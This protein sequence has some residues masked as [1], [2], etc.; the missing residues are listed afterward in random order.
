MEEQRQVSCGKR[1]IEYTLTRKKVKNINLRVKPDGSIRVSANR[2]VSY[3]VID[4]FIRDNQSYIFRALDR[5]KEQR[6]HMQ[7]PQGYEDG[8]RVSILGK[9][10]CLKVV[11]SQEES[12]YTDGSSLYLLVKDRDDFKRKEKL[13]NAWIKKLQTETFD[14]ICREIY[15]EF[16]KYGIAYP[17]IKVRKMSARWGSCQPQKGVV[18]LNGRL[19]AVP[20]CCIEYVVLHEFAHFIHPNH[21]RQFYDFVA[22]M[23]PDWKERKE[24]LDRWY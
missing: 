4:S 23:M 20:Y 3:R 11:E 22:G 7:L 8:E 15:P 17:E 18:T 1:T 9:A 24:E 12:I 6:R 2:R 10:L 5:F 13:V 16:Q 14:R 21:S 19:V